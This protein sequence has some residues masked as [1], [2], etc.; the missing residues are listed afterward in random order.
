MKQLP[1]RFMF[2][3]GSEFTRGVGTQV[4]V[5]PTEVGPSE[6]LW[7]P[8][9]VALTATGAG[10]THA[11]GD[12][13]APPPRSPALR[14]PPAVKS[15]SWLRSELVCALHSRTSRSSCVTRSS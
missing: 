8:F 1:T 12:P 7:G 3:P 5:A 13:D 11:L 10:G 14:S 2:T 4:G 6:D 15:A 9:D